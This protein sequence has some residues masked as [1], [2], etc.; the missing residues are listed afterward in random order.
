MKKIFNLKCLFIVLGIIVLSAVTVTC[1]MAVMPKA[2]VVPSE[3]DKGLTF[4]QASKEDKPILA[5][6][7]V[8]WCTYCKRF[9]PKLD[10]VRNINK[11]DLNVVLINMDDSK[12]DKFAKDYRVT[13]FPTVYIIDPNYDN[14]VHINN[15]FFDSVVDFNTE[16]SRYIKFR[17]LVNKGATCK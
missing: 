17:K 11:S 4:E 1:C 6:F 12:N 13:G 9:M 5:V 7:Y 15:A 3:Y 16:V 8:D 2:D 14:R 10:K